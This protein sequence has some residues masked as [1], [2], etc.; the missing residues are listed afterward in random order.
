MGWSLHFVTLGMGSESLTI[1]IRLY[2][3]T[4]VVV[5]DYSFHQDV[6]L[7]YDADLD[8]SFGN[9]EESYKMDWGLDMFMVV[10]QSRNVQSFHSLH[11]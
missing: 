6:C 4:Q 3:K 9:D 2:D 5:V 8:V 1:L 10:I 11:I 7:L